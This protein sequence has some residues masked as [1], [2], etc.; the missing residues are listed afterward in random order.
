MYESLAWA[1][2]S[3]IAGAALGIWLTLRLGGAQRQPP[4][5]GLFAWSRQNTIISPPA[6][7]PSRVR[8]I[9]NWDDVM[10]QSPDDHSLTFS[11]DG[12]DVTFTAGELMRFLRSGDDGPNRNGWKGANGTYSQ[13]LK[14]LSRYHWCFRKGNRWAWALWLGTRERRVRALALLIDGGYGTLPPPPTPAQEGA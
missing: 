3:F 7:D 6:R 11:F 1:L 12:I 2:A 9:A 8:L 13:L 4:R 10:T 5:R 14:V